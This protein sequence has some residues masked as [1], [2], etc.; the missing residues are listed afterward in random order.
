MSNPAQKA[1][2]PA[3]IASPE[4]ETP[5]PQEQTPVDEQSAH[6]GAV[7]SDIMQTLPPT[8]ESTTA[9]NDENAAAEEEIDPADEIT[10]G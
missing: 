9:T 7:E 2:T 8:N 4:K 10:P 3:T 6:Q 1:Q 5:T